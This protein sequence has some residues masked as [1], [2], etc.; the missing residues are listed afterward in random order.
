M[1]EALQMIPKTQMSD[2]ERVRDLQRKLYLKAKRENQRK[3]K[4]YNRWAFQ[5]LVDS[6]GLIDPYKSLRTMAAVNV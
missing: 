3:G 4:L 1:S 2:E 6:Y 5:V